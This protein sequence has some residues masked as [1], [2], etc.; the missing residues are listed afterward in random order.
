M[1]MSGV[2]RD[3]SRVSKDASDLLKSPEGRH[4]RAGSSSLVQNDGTFLSSVLNLTGTLPMVYARTTYHVPIEIFIPPL[5]PSASPIVFVRPVANMVIKDRHPQVAM[6]GAV[7]ITWRPHS[8]NLVECCATMS[9]LFGL[10]PPLFSKPIAATPLTVT[11]DGNTTTSATATGSDDVGQAM[12]RLLAE[13]REQEIAR[14]VE[15]ANAAVRAARQAEQD[16]EKQR[17]EIQQLQSHLT[18]K[19]HS[20]LHEYM[21]R[22]KQATEQQVKIQQELTM[23]TQYLTEHQF[24][25][26]NSRKETVQQYDQDI[27]ESIQRM[28]EYIAIM[29]D[30][31]KKQ[32]EW[33]EKNGVN[34]DNLALPADAYSKQVLHLTA[35]NN[36]LSD[37]FYYLDK[38]L[39]AG[40]ISLDRQLKIVRQMARRQFYIRARLLQIMQRKGPQDD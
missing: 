26:L 37:A 24:A 31:E 27:S 36:A 6:D 19:I 22:I 13:S 20:V 33:E 40:A 35:K 28:Q 3:P 2:Y 25:Y 7:H 10:N 38:T 9:S 39:E 1:R 5:Y 32:K 17:L 30:D 11:H 18:F 12:S 15:E 23:G 34:I 14:D 29:E 8:S 21:N 4:I 16:E